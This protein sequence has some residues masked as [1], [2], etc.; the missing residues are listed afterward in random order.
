MR[1]AVCDDEA[2]FRNVLI[3][4]LNRYSAEKNVLFNIFEFDDG[5]KLIA[6]KGA[7]DIIFLDHQMNELNGLDT[8]RLL[9]EK[10]KDTKVIFVSSYSEV[11]FDSMKYNAFRF[12]VKP[13][14][15]EKLWE[16]LDSAEAEFSS[17]Y[18]IMARDTEYNENVTIPERDMIY[19][20]ADN[21]YTYITTAGGTYRYGDNISALEE[22]LR[23]G[24]FFR[25]NRSYIVNL[26]HVTAYDKSTIT[27]SNGHKA[28]LSRTKYKEFAA[29]YM[30]HLK[31]T[32]TE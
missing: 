12:I 14:Q 3:D 2:Y 22:E 21:I 23:S 18:K 8:I 30:A 24:F 27:L 1:I 16:A 26:C 5:K 15:Q 20:Q 25:S 32:V 4:L 11:V 29:R 19:A 7:Y 13:V 31:Q 9:R 28:V 6:D 17:A 10:N